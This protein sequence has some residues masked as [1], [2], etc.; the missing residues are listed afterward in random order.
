[1]GRLDAFLDGEMTG[2]GGGGGGGAGGAETR[3]EAIGHWCL[4]RQ[5]GGFQGRVNKDPDTC[6]S[7]WVGGSLQLLGQGGGFLAQVDTAPLLAFHAECDF[8]KGGFSKFPDMYPDILHSYYSVC[9]LGLHGLW[10]VKPMR[11]ELAVSAEAFE[12]VVKRNREEERGERGG[13]GGAA[14]GAG[15]A[16]A[17]GAAGEAGAAG[18]ASQDVKPSQ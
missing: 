14:G 17:A 6:Y 18:A 2:G 7:F 10:G 5:V 9:A 12:S 1:M 8:A 16:G 15:E 4:Q 3:R 13:G 11:A